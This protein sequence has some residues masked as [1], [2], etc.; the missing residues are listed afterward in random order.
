MDF[1]PEVEKP[2]TRWMRY[3]DAEFLVRYATPLQYQRW[4]RRMVQT[5]IMRETKKGTHEVAAGRDLDYYESIASEW[6]MDWRGNVRVGDQENPPYSPAV[7]AKALGNIADLLK[8]I[9]EAVEDTDGFF[10]QDG[11]AKA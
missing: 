6:V 11:T 1:G 9:S 5:G 10:G 4:Q 2:K 3:R 7:M 8:L